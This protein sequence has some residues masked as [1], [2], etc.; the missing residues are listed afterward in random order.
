MT[1]KEKLVKELD[2]LGFDDTINCC[3]DVEDVVK[4]ILS[5]RKRII[6]PLV[7]VKLD[8]L[9]NTSYDF[10]KAIDQTIKNALREE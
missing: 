5:D 9:D 1:A 4:Y 2:K 8:G 7:K 6:E 3:V 10:I